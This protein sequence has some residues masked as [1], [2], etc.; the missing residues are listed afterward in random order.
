MRLNPNIGMVID[1]A[2]QSGTASVEQRMSVLMDNMPPGME[3]IPVMPNEV[4]GLKAQGIDLNE[5]IQYNYLDPET[6]E[7]KTDTYNKYA[8]AT[9]DPMS[10]LFISEETEESKIASVRIY[11]SAIYAGLER[12]ITGSDKTTTFAPD[13]PGAGEK[14]DEFYGDLI[15]KA[16]L[17]DSKSF[18]SLLRK[19]TFK[20][21]IL[22]D[23][24]IQFLDKDNRNVGE[25]LDFKGLN[26]RDTA[27]QLA[28]ILGVNPEVFDDKIKFG[29]DQKV[30]DK[31]IIEFGEAPEIKLDLT[32]NI[33]ATKDEYTI[34]EAIVDAATRADE[35]SSFGSDNE[36]L[37]SS[38]ESIVNQA[39]SKSNAKMKTSPKITL[40]KDKKILTISG[41]NSKGKT[42][43][44]T[45]EIYSG[46]G[47]TSQGIQAESEQFFIDFLSNINSSEDYASGGGV[48]YTNK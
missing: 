1:T 44:V 33:G 6:G 39:L 43:T 30:S 42:I 19:S 38:L 22:S 23:G 27:I 34:K 28:S 17:G 47:V 25:P 32:T 8:I 7:T 29:K 46:T 10:T 9:L 31:G 36:V 20:T 13:R 2:S 24:R 35:E 4:E 18:E 21:K 5:K 11:K 14:T 45:K 41:V 40:D 15:K 26:A 16:V 3:Q 48:D 12:K 37:A